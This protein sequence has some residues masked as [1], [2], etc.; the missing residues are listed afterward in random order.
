MLLKYLRRYTRTDSTASQ[1]VQ[2]VPLPADKR[3]TVSG[4]TDRTE[5]LDAGAQRGLA[6]ESG[7]KRE[8]S[9]G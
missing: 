1:V 2:Q 8:L 6:A 7:G 3:A 9:D 4:L 5:I